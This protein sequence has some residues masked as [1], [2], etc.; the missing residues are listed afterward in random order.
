MAFHE[1]RGSQEGSFAELKSD[2][3]MDYVPVTPEVGN[4]L[5]RSAAMLAHNLSRELQMN[6]NRYREAHD[7]GFHCVS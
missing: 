4:R 1:G 6:K 5:Y 7:F 3:Q 2:R